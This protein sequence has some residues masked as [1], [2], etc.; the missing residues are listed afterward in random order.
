MKQAQ[1]LQIEDLSQQQKANCNLAGQEVRQRKRRS[2]R[3]TDESTFKKL[4]MKTSIDWIYLAAQK[5]KTSRRIDGARTGDTDASTFKKLAMKP[6]SNWIYLE[7]QEV[8]TS[9]QS[10]LRCIHDLN[11]HMLILSLIY[12]DT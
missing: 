8:E 5:L 10:T 11:Q 3:D 12:K 7:A 4:A 9:R 2:A 1:R 6:S